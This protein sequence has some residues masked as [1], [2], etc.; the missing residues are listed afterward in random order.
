VIIL[1]TEIFGSSPRVRV[2]DLLISHPGTEYTKTDIANYSGIARSTLY[3]F[4]EE[5]EE[6]GLLKKSKKV[7]N[8]QL[9]MVNM[10]SEVTKL[11]SAFQLSLAEIEIKKQLENE[12]KSDYE[13]KLKEFELST[14]N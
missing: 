3:D 8:A 2:I 11:I 13:D 6:Y 10:D 14:S 1:L 12:E 9:Y 4:L 7:G 5:L